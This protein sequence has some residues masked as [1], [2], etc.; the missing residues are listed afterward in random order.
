MSVHPQIQEI[1]DNLAKA[2]LPAME[3]L[4]PEAARAQMEA[5]VKARGVVPEAVAGTEE[6]LIPGSGGGIPVRLYRPAAAPDGPLPTLVYFHGGGHVLGSPDT[7]D[8]VARTLCNGGKCAVLSVN[9]RKAPEHKFPAAVEDAFAA[10]LWTSEHGAERGLDPNRIAVGGDSAGGNLAAVVALMARDADQPSLQL[11]LMVYPIVDYA[12]IG[13][14][15]EQYATGYGVLTGELMRWFQRYYLNDESEIADW[16][17]S[18]I[19]AESHAGL[20]P[21]L[22]ITAGCDVL[23]DD[24]VRYA[25]ALKAAGV[26]VTH[27][28]YPGMIHTFFT[29]PSEIEGAAQSQAEA[30]AALRRAFT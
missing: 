26:E 11:Q 28:D 12:C 18:P 22:V 1:L 2:D 25:E 3:S 29:M 7:H 5:M 23:H 30:S 27:T 19:H 17:A 4:A 24:G 20:A 6:F 16:R 13:D 21:A 10:T 8:G 9:Y 15:Y 14:S